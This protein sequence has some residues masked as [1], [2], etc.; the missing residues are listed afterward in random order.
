MIS[1]T[2][3]TRVEYMYLSNTTLFD[4]RDI[5][6]I[7]YIRFNYMFRRLSIAI[8]RLYMKYL[9]SSCTEFIMCC[10]QGVPGGMCQISGGVP[11]SKVYG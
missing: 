11:Y 8:F 2:C 9:V 5:S 1:S 3:L 10:I 7:Y 6:S 4:S